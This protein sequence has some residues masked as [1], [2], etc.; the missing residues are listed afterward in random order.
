MTDATAVKREMS[1]LLKQP[2][3]RLKDDMLLSDVVSESFVLIETVIELQ[4]TFG[5]RLIQDDMRHVRTVGD[6]VLLLTEKAS[7]T[8]LLR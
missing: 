4:E 2:I 7:R 6:L 1:E 3:A 5:V 8:P